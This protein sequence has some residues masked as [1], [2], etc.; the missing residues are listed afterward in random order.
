MSD[1]SVAFVALL[2]IPLPTVS[3]EGSPRKRYNMKKAN[4]ILIAVAVACITTGCILMLPEKDVRNTVGGR[5]APAPGPGA[6]DTR[7]IRAAPI[8]CV[9]GYLLMIPAILYRKSEK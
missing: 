7:R 2:C 9:V 3:N 4:F 6:F 8:P 1:F 5:Y